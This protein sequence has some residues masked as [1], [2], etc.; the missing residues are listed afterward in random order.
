MLRYDF[1]TFSV[2]E[3]SDKK[4]LEDKEEEIY[5]W[6]K[7]NI[8]DIINL[9][10]K[11]SNSPYSYLI[12]EYPILV[13]DEMPTAYS[14]TLLKVDSPAMF[15]GDYVAISTYLVAKTIMEGILA[16]VRKR[17]ARVIVASN[18][19]TKEI[20]TIIAHEYTHA[21][22]NHGVLR[23]RFHKRTG[24]KDDKTYLFACEIQANRGVYVNR[25]AFV[26]ELGVNEEKFID[27]VPDIATARTLDNIYIAIKNVYKDKIN[28][29]NNNNEENNNNDENQ[30][31][32]QGQK[33][34]SEPN[35]QS[36]ENKQNQGDRQQS[37]QQ[38]GSQSEE[39]KQNQGDRQQSKQQ[40]KSDSQGDEAGKELNSEQKEALDRLFKQEEKKDTSASFLHDYDEEEVEEDNEKGARTLL[41]EYNQRVET[42]NIKKSLLK[43]RA[44]L[45]GDLSKGKV[46]TYS[47]PS[48]RQPNGD[49]FKKGKKNDAR[50]N[51]SILL[52]LDASGSMSS[53]TIKQVTEATVD[54]IKALGRDISN[55]Y[56]CLHRS[57]VFNLEKL[58][59]YK[60]AINGYNPNGGNNFLNVYQKAVELNCDVVLNVG[61][62]LDSIEAWAYCFTKDGNEKTGKGLLKT[63]KKLTWYDC[64]V[65][66]LAE[67][68]MEWY[69]KS[70]YIDEKLGGVKRKT[71]DLVGSLRPKS[72]FIEQLEENLKKT[73]EERRR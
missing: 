33:Q 23:Q 67:D 7:D 18:N 34:Q 44:V 14:I 48:R 9:Y 61:D 49:L 59:D 30:S 50:F 69:F 29:N 12:R 56:I 35:S 54:I 27:D 16:K 73:I 39:N 64:L 38:S 8:H 28:N 5:R 55:C 53:T 21:L 2:D 24:G 17:G 62:G 26:Y 22:Y 37:K 4:F 66:K 52:A 6:C 43:L 45:K 65:Y 58:K 36:E 20:L 32:K 72:D 41:E 57:K 3:D 63:N 68:S 15:T 11:N 13:D 19:L 46:P 1:V 60:K 51:P 40:S 10:F 25:D 70:I 31:N 47:R 71:L 42:A